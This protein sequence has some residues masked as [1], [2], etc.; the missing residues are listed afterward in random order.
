MS[1]C[2][3][4]GRPRSGRPR[5]QVHEGRA[6]RRGS[7]ALAGLAK[8]C[9]EVPALT[10]R[11]RGGLRR[12]LSP[13][14]S[15]SATGGTRGRLPCQRGLAPS[16]PGLRP[17]PA[18]PRR[19]L[20]CGSDEGQVQTPWGAPWAAR[21]GPQQVRTRTGP[22]AGSGVT[23]ATR[24]PRPHLSASRVELVCPVGGE[25]LG[26]PGTL[27]G[28]ARPRWLCPGGAGGSGAPPGGEAEG[29][30]ASPQ[31]AVVGGDSHAGDLLLETRVP[32]GGLIRGAPLWVRT[33]AWVTGPPGS[34]QQ[35]GP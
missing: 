25:A 11:P 35:R 31:A 23:G 32:G 16:P 14:V 7:V 6:A 26:L 4:W 2:P 13:G 8:G 20:A 12:G 17:G 18:W 34:R 19:P 27:Q 29:P 5:T 1:C 15:M 33:G 28:P 10:R 3:R 24:L 21:A 30:G 9:P 22:P